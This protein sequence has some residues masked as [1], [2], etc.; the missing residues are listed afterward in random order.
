MIELT[1]ANLLATIVADF[2]NTEL[3]YI[4]DFKTPGIMHGAE[5]SLDYHL[6]FLTEQSYLVA[7]LAIRDIPVWQYELSALRIRQEEEFYRGV[8][9]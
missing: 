6:R 5:K 2:G 9:L 3:N 4:S 7:E 1:L 8:F